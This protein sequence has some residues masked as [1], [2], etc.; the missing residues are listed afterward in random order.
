MENTLAKEAH[1]PSLNPDKKSLFT[2]LVR[3][4]STNANMDI[5]KASLHTDKN[6][7]GFPREIHSCYNKVRV[8]WSPNNSLTLENVR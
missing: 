6:R 4:R 3:Q 7:K 5:R 8:S 2:I 1:K